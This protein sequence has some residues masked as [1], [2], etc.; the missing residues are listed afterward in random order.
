[1]GGGSFAV[2]P[3]DG[4]GTTTLERVFA[5]E[6]AVPR[7]AQTGYLG[8]R[9]YVR[10]DHGVEPVGFQIYRSL[11]QLFIRLFSV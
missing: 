6:I 9:V 10:F 1:M 11:R 3:R 8:Q 5:I 4:Q 2:D 7:E